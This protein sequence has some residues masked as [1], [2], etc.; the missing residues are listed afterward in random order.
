MTKPVIT[1]CIPVKDNLRYLKGCIESIKKNSATSYDVLVYVDQSTD[2]TLEWLRAESIPFIE[3]TTG[4]LQGIAAGYNRCI[5]AAKTEV[6]CMFHADMYLGLGFDTNTLKHLQKGRIV[7]GTRI[8]PP[9]HPPGPEKILKAFG[10]YPETFKEE[11]FSEFITKE[12]KANKDLTSKGMFAPWVAYK[13][14]LLKVGLH[15][16]SLHSYYEDSDL[17]NRLVLQ[18]CELL[19]SRDAF[20]YHY[21]CRGGQFQDGV[22]SVTKDEFFHEM[23]KRSFREFVRK[24]KSAPLHDDNL[25]PII[26]KVYTTAFVIVN[27]PQELLY[28]LEPWADE[29]HID[30]NYTPYIEKEQPNTRTDLKSKFKIVTEQTVPQTSV[31]LIADGSGITPRHYQEFIPQLPFIVESLEKPGLYNWDRFV[32][33]V[34]DQNVYYPSS[35]M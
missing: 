12:A 7:A 3:N 34:L 22:E 31:T 8:E 4:K 18:G 33:R 13:E 23:K 14:D 27:C 26:P 16:E 32:I 5:T 10:N 35:K 6:V 11:Q 19:Q 15:D 1:Y 9:L 29:L 20:V 28:Y 17:F 25:Y 30:C 24:W 2:G 21:T